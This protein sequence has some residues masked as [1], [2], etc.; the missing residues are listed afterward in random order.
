M[1]DEDAQ[2]IISIQNDIE[3]LRNDSAVVTCRV[4]NMVK[5][6][7]GVVEHLATISDL[8]LHSLNGV[9]EPD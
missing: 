8:L 6:L 2:R 7:Q 4:I 5:E 9:N 1:N 3:R